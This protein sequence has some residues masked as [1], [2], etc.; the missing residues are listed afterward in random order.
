M[1]LWSAFLDHRGRVAH[2][3]THYFPAYER[4]FERY[5]NRPC[6][7]WEIGCGAGGSLQLWKKYLGPYAQIVGLD[8]LP[9]A[10]AFAEDQIEIRIGDQA[11][12][13]FLR[14]VLDEF[15]PPDVVLDDG[16][17][18]M[19]DITKSFRYLYPRMSRSG[20]YVV[21]DLHTAYWAEYGGGL[22]RPESFIEVSKSLIDELNAVHAREAIVV[23][24]LSPLVFRRSRAPLPSGKLGSGS[25]AMRRPGRWLPP[26]RL[27]RVGQSRRSRPPAEGGLHPPR[28]SRLLRLRP[29][30]PAS[31]ADSS[32]VIPG[33][34]PPAAGEASDAV[35]I[36][37][38]SLVVG[39]RVQVMVACRLCACECCPRS[40]R[41]SS[42]RSGTRVAGVAQRGHS[43]ACREPLD[44][45][46][47]LPG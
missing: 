25:R 31:S 13:E 41:E 35:G 45:T 40:R 39:P 2:K 9:T 14:G 34:A 36:L 27:G 23:V 15:G 38:D 46:S 37:A 42:S 4:H 10:A 17:H 26:I 29:T 28:R 8:I 32:L 16:S 20:V 19:S 44:L 21:E 47:Q 43:N 3:W 33:R 6:L 22:G 30:P 24:R 11:D 5:V 7:F 1:T 18:M 12:E